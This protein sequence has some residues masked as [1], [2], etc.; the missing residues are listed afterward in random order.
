MLK[1]L[2]PR[3]SPAT[4]VAVIA[5]IAALGGTAIAAGG[6]TAT[7]KKQ[8]KKIATKV[9]NGRIGGASV[10]HANTA[11]TATKATTADTATKATTA[12][13][14]TKATS[15]DTATKATSADTATKATSADTATKAATATDAANLGGVP[16]SGYQQACQP[17]AIAADVYVKGS[18]TFSSTY[19]SGGSL[20]DP[21]NCTGSAIKAQV[22]RSS[23]GVYLVDFPGVDPAGHLVATGNATVD[24]TSTQHPEDNVTYKLVLDAGLG[25]TVYQVEIA[26]GAGTLVDR[27]FSF[28]VD[29]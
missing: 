25:R 23:A 24:S 13:T 15:A 18:A 22:K 28:S 21:F 27:E 7:Q 5:L 6:L 9:F 12:N 3:R 1:K 19:T 8:V 26:T 17:G 20:Q 2:N 29:G 10:A 16:A 11:D 4:F 14:A